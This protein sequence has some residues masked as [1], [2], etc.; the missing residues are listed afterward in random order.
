MRFSVLWIIL[1]SLPASA[2]CFLIILPDCGV[3][4]GDMQI[5]NA[6]APEPHSN[7]QLLGISIVFEKIGISIVLQV[8]SQAMTIYRSWTLGRE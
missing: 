1:A 5:Q 3:L 6:F 7:F 2:Q 4:D 8:V